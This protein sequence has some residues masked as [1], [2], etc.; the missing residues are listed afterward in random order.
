LID[1]I[2]LSHCGDGNSIAGFS[3]VT[4]QRHLSRPSP[5]SGACDIGAVEVQVTVSTPAPA[6]AAVVQQPHF[7]G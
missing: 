7:T 5:A 3:V 2:P 6:A 4:D 1:K